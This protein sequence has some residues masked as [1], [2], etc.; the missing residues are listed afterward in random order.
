MFGLG[1]GEILVIALIAL[2]LFGK[3]DLPK[4][5]R[6]ISKRVNEFRKMANDAQRSWNEIR[7]DVT[8]TLLEEPDKKKA[9]PPKAESETPPAT[10]ASSTLPVIQTADGAVAQGVEDSSDDN[11]VDKRADA[12]NHHQERNHES[13]TPSADNSKLPT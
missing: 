6:G 10:E 13:A 12:D 2:L 5:V 9:E 4:T 3:E 7:D 8:R 11:E 1:S